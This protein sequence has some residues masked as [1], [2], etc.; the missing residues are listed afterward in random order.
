MNLYIHIYI[1][2]FIQRALK[3]S[4]IFWESPSRMLVFFVCFIFAFEVEKG[5]Q[6]RLQMS[7][8]RTLKWSQWGYRI[9]MKSTFLGTGF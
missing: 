5:L 9:Q 3:L 8:K 4:Q 7:P 1:Y 6:V 2:I